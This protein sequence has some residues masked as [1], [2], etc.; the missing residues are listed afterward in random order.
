MREIAVSV[1]KIVSVRKNAVCLICGRNILTN[2]KCFKTGH[3]KKK[4]ERSLGIRTFC[5]D[6]VNKIY[7]D[8]DE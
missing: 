6:C 1:S 5:V 3:N 8:G 7:V 2:E 4:T